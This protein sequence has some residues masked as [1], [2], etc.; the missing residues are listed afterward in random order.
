MI[1]VKDVKLQKRY[2]GS[3]RVEARRTGYNRSE[4]LKATKKGSKGI[5]ARK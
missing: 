5:V 1:G 4:G 2:E 3:D